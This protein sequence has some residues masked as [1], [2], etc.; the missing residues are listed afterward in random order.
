MNTTIPSGITNGLKI[1][2]KYNSIALIIRHSIRGEI[3]HGQLGNDVTLT[4]EG[5]KLAVTLGQL[6]G[7]RIRTITSSPITRCTETANCILDGAGLNYKVTTTRLLGDPG[8]FISDGS[9]AW[10]NF[11]ALGTSGVM[12]HLA[13]KNHALPGMRTPQEAARE[14]LGAILQPNTEPGI[15]LYVTHDVILSGIVGQLIGGITSKEH[16]PGYLDGAFFWREGQQ[17][18]GSYRDK[19]TLLKL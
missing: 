2:S 18:F 15:H 7:D 12:M 19:K 1:I 8:I 6:I 13:N 11:Q 10:Q 3:L 9:V 5:K 17:T 14:L 16:L 4:H